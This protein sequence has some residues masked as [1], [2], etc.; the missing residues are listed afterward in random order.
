MSQ[1][2]TAGEGLPHLSFSPCLLLPVPVCQSHTCSCVGFFAFASFSPASALWPSPP[3]TALRQTAP[4][5]WSPA[6]SPL[7]SMRMFKGYTVTQLWWIFHLINRCEIT[8]HTHW[9]RGCVPQNLCVKHQFPNGTISARFAPLL[10]VFARS[11][12][13][14]HRGEYP[15]T[16]GLP[17]VQCQLSWRVSLSVLKKK[18]KKRKNFINW[19]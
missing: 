1:T 12:A 17:L 8:S 4:N 9:L 5:G 10:W 14:A 3:Q 15:S 6:S 16:S 11:C 19:I 18:K 2:I 13:G 7:P